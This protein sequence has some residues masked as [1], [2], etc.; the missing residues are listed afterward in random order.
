MSWGGYR[1]VQLFWRVWTEGCFQEHRNVQQR[2]ARLMKRQISM[3]E[4]LGLSYL[5]G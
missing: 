1:D 4:P 2:S 5:H 3:I